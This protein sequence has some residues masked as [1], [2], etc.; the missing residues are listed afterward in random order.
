VTQRPEAREVS[1]DKEDFH[2]KLNGNGR[3]KTTTEAA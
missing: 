3:K 1:V 2:L